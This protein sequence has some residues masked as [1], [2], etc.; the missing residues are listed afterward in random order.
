M[1]AYGAAKTKA[2]EPSIAQ[3]H[4]ARSTDTEQAGKPPSDAANMNAINRYRPG[5]CAARTTAHGTAQITPIP[6][7]TYATDAE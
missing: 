2:P 1:T 5:E 6:I 3:A 4:A 7:T